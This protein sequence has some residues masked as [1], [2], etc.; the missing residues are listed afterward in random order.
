MAL[1]EI[2]RF[3]NDEKQVNEF[4][5]EEP[6]EFLVEFFSKVENPQSFKVLDIG[7][8]G[9]R[10]AE[11]LVR[12]GFDV[13][14]CDLH[15]S[16]VQA[17]VERI[18]KLDKEAA[19]KIIM[20]DMSHLPYED[21]VFDYIVSNGVFHNVKSLDELK[22][23]VKEA[24]RVLK[25]NGTIALNIFSSAVIDPTLTVMPGEEYTYITPQGLPMVLVPKDYLVGLLKD[26]NFQQDG[27]ITEKETSVST[28]QRC[29]LKGLFR[30]II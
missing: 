12:M 21:M 11:M 23:C 29:V 5:N 8:G 27:E 16:M 24:S 13:S 25:N 6:S 18:A 20:A 7:C 10:N 1:N 2:E 14:A 3:W 9:G 28:G 4:F 30:K 15:E 22:S 19:S 17:T 26:Y